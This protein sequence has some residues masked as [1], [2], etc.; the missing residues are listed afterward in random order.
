MRKI[1]FDAF[2]TLICR[3]GPRINPYARL[4]QALASV[5]SKTPRLHF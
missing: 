4:L 1:V 5:G 3:T 2:G